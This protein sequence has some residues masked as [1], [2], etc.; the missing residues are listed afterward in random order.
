MGDIIMKSKIF[1]DKENTR[2]IIECACGSP[3]FL[4]FEW[5]EEDVNV[6][7][8][9]FISSGFLSFWQRFKACIEYLFVHTRNLYLQD[10]IITEKNI[11]D[12]EDM[13]K[14][15][16]KHLIKLSEKSKKG[17]EQ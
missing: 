10:I 3:E 1:N 13:I 17:V 16:K 6:V 14:D 12:L 2:H 11:S 7:T 5:G 15:Y 8:A 9:S 4:L